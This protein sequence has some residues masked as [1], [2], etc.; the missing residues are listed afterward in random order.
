MKK[1]LKSFATKIR[2]KASD[3]NKGCYEGTANYMC[4]KFPFFDLDVQILTSLTVIEIKNKEIC[5][6]NNSF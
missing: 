4:K 3:N 2:R 1:K 6:S 5:E